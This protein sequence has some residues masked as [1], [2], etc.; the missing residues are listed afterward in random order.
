MKEPKLT[1]AQYIEGYCISVAFS[2]GTSGTVDLTDLLWGPIFKPLNDL[3]FFK[4]FAFNPELNTISWPNGA[5]VAP[6]SLYRR[7]A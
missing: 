6:E 3:G 4:S 7:I 2:D 5:D 1:S